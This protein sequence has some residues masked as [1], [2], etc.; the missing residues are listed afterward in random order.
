MIN[1]QD[2][3][4]PERAAGHTVVGTLRMLTGLWSSQRGN[5]RDILVYLPPSYDQGNRCYPVIYMHDGQNLFDQVTSFAG[6]WEVDE[7][8]QA[9][10]REGL[11]AIV[12]GIA[13]TGAERLDEYSPFHEPKQ[14]G[15]QGEQYLEF[16][17]R[18]VKPLIDSSFRTLPD[19]VHTGII[20]SS[21]GG[22]ISLFAFFCYPDIFGL[23]GA[24]SPSL[25]FA[26]QAIFPV[27]QQASFGGGKIYLDAGTQEYSNPGTHPLLCRIRSYHYLA[28]VRK[29]YQL[30][31]RKGYHPNQN[32][33][34]VEAEGAIHS[35]KAWASRLP[36]AIRFLLQP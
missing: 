34:Y 22:L 2:Y 24:M 10:S 6:E 29:M 13:N 28:T 9:L 18:T 33:L 15:G 26:R 25:G 23:V 8:M 4:T 36:G 1:W 16:V 17:T 12:V 30:L 19:R 21:M 27:I 5:R 32:L 7:T 31:R 14:G 20:G 35:E 11:E 3:V